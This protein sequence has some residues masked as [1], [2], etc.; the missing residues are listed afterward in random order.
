MAEIKFKL[1]D[2]LSEVVED[3]TQ[4]VAVG[5]INRGSFSMKNSCS[6]DY[7]SLNDSEKQ[8]ANNFID[9]MKTKVL[10]CGDDGDGES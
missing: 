4:I 2:H 9:M 3:G 10:S 1:T 7:A 8:I 6:V 5:F